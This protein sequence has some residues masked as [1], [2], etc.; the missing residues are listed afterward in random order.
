MRL[1]I[2]ARLI[3]S[4]LM[5][6]GKCVNCKTPISKRYPIVE[7]VTMALSLI[8]AWQLGPTPQAAL[9]IVVTWFFVSMT[10]I[11]AD[12]LLLPDSL[13]VTQMYLLYSFNKFR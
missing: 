6:G 9:G 3:I 1:S 12:H 5:L 2:F 8:V 11:D 13:S 4:Y 7:F 10:K